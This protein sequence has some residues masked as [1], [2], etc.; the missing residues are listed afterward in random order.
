MSLKKLIIIVAIIIVIIII[1][2]LALWGYDKAQQE[3]GATPASEDTPIVTNSIEK[4]DVLNDYYSVKEIVDKYY[5]YLIRTQEDDYRIIDEEVEASLQQEEN[6]KKTAI[7]NM[8]DEKYTQYKGITESNVFD[9]IEQKD[10]VDVSIS[11]MLVSQQD[12]NMY[13][14]IVY[15][16]T[17]DIATNNIEEFTMLVETDRTNRTFKI[18]LEDYI[19]DNIGEISEGG[20]LQFT[21]NETI[22]NDEYNTYDYRQISTETYILDM[23]NAFKNNMMYDLKTAYEELDENYKQSKFSEYQDFENYDKDKYEE[24]VSISIKQYQ[25]NEFDGYTQYV[26]V[27]QNG[28]QYV[29]NETGIMDFKVILDTYTIDLPQ[30]IETYNSSD[31]ATKVALNLQKIFDAINDG[32]Y[33]YVYNKLDDT[34]KQNNFPTIESFEEYVRNNFYENNTINQ[35]SYTVE[36]NIYVYSLNISNTDNSEEII[37]K[38]FLVQLG[39]GTDFVMSFSVE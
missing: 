35:S 8:L 31:E 18:I 11:N 1:T 24:I 32:D 25:I 23:F 7:Y 13:I 26:L 2:L 33:N 34:F 4:V 20:N 36:N 9:I 16:S 39:E 15:G 3:Y 19:N 14:Y 29:I 21:A 6:N 5:E 27:D 10:D 30:F 17:R 12:V 38:D 37:T 22:N 28:K